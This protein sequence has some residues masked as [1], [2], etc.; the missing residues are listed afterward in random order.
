[1]NNYST[2]LQDYK[3]NVY[4]QTGEDG[5]IE[6]ILEIIP[7]KDKWCVEFGAWDGFYSS[8]TAYLIQDKDY[9]AVLIEANSGKF[10]QL[11]KNFASN[12]NVI[13][14]NRFVG[15]ENESR[16]DAILATTA[17]PHDFDFLSI[18]IDGNDYHVWNIV[19]KYNP[20]IVCI[21]FNPTIPTNIR[22]VQPAD[23]A[24]SQG[25]SLLSL[26]ELGRKKG[27]ELVSV[28][29]FN[30]FFVRSEYYSLFN[31]ECNSPE[32]LRTNLDAIT[33]IFSGFDGKI[34]LKGFCRLPWHDLELDENKMQCLPQFLRKPWDNYNKFERLMF[35]FYLILSGRLDKVIAQINKTIPSLVRRFLLNPKF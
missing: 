30:A 7:N 3:R 24:I 13:T 6:K 21:E 17:I 9:H 35:F 27:Y 28:L 14:L 25:A 29:L 16:L 32:V 12:R 26:V 5:I 33:Y 20:K 11:Q 10:N 19:N 4:S 22:F 1:V 23:A 18:D 15:W 31:I 2:W 34:F 8:N